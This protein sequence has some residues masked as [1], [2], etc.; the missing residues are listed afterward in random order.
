[1]ADP[2]A[3]PTL[4][5]QSTG[6]SVTPGVG[7]P[8]TGG[9]TPPPPVPA[10]TA[11]TG[12]MPW[13]TLGRTLFGRDS[14]S[15]LGGIPLLG[16]VVGAV[17][18]LA[19][20]GV[21]KPI[22]GAASIASHIPLGWLPG[23]ADEGFNQ[24][25]DWM[26]TN[27]PAAYQEW[28]VTKAA[29]D[30]DVLGGGN[31]R[32]DFNRQWTEHYAD[33]TKQGFTGLGAISRDYE[34]GAQGVGSLGGALA[35]GI[36]GLLGIL[37]GTVQR[38]IAGSQVGGGFGDM[39][40]G[41]AA[42]VPFVGPLLG[43]AGESARLAATKAGLDRVAALQ[44]VDPATLSDV[45]KTAVEHVKDG[46]WT[47]DHALNYLVTHNQSY[48]NEFL[49]QLAGQI[50]TDPLTF[51]TMGAGGISKAGLTAGK[52]LVESGIPATTALERL[53]V[54]AHTVQTSSLGPAFRVARGLIDPLGVMP[55]RTVTQ[56]VIDLSAG[57]AGAAFRRA[58]GEAAYTSIFP[59]AAK[60]GFADDLTSAIGAYEADQFR[61][62]TSIDARATQLKTT[63]GEGLVH[64][65]PDDVIEPMLQAAPKDAVDSLTTFITKTSK[66]T[67]NESDIA[68]LASRMT[69]SFGRTTAEWA[70]DIAKMSREEMSAWHAITYKV[71][72]KGYMEAL[73][74][75]DRSA[76]KGDL[77]LDQM[78]LMND[79][80]L[81]DVAAQALIADIKAEKSLIGK[82]DLW[83]G[84]ALRYSRIADL[85]RSTG[86]KVHLGQMTAALDVMIESLPKRALVDELN[87]PALQ[88]LND[89]LARNTIDG[90]PLWNLGFRPAE[91]VAWGMKRHPVSGNWI[92]ERDPTISHV[93][94][95]TPA[96]RPY[97][98]TT[99]NILGQIIGIDK[100]TTLA[101]PVDSV[102][103]LAR[104]ATDQVSGLRLSQNMSQRFERTMVEDLKVPKNMAREIFAKARELAGWDRTTI[105]GLAP[106]ENFWQQMGDII[107]EGMTVSHGGK[108]VIL[109]KHLL[110]DR[111][112]WAAEGDAR[113][114]GL[115]SNFTQR[116]RNTLRRQGMDSQNWAGQMTVTMYN[117]LR[118]SQPTFLIQRIADG[119]YFNALKGVMPVGRTLY[120]PAHQALS[121]IM[122]NI[123][124]TAM[125]RDFA[126]DM[127][128]YALR[129]QFSQSLR[130]AVLQKAG[131]S[132]KLDAIANTPDLIVRNNMIAQMH[133][134]LGEVLND[135]LNDT[136]TAIARIGETD[137]ATAAEM[138][139]N[140]NGDLAMSFAHMREVFSA[141][142]GRALSDDEVGLK[143]LQQQFASSAR[144]TVSPAGKIDL[145]GI[146]GEA[147]YM[148]PADI[149]ELKALPWDAV[150]HAWGLENEVALRT[151][152]SPIEKV[153]TG[154]R[155]LPNRGI[156]AFVEFLKEDLGAHPDVI[157]RFTNAAHFRWDTYWTG[158]REDLGLSGRVTSQMQAVIAQSAT[159]RGMTP[160]D[161]LSQMMMTNSGNVKTSLGELAD[162][163][164]AG[165]GKGDPLVNLSKLFRAHLDLSAQRTL[166]EEFL[167][168][169][170]HDADAA[171]VDLV[172]RRAGGE[173]IKNPEVEATV[174][175]FSK[176][177]Q[178][179]FVGQFTEN[180]NLIGKRAWEL[181]TAI[182]TNRAF[183]FNH[184][185]A[186]IEQLLLQKIGIA[187]ADAFRLA[188]M[189]TSRN[190]VSRSLN[191]PVFGMYPS[192]YMWG[193][194]LPEMAKFVA[195]NPYAATYQMLDVE[196]AIAT[197]REYD[198]KFANADGT[199]D[200]SSVAFLTGYL[201]P[202]LPWDD[203]QAASPPWMRAAQKSGFDPGMMAAAE[204]A[205]ISP[206]RWY[207][208]FAQSI[209]ETI[210]FTQ[211][212]LQPQPA[213]FPGLDTGGPTAPPPAPT[214]TAAPTF[215]GPTSGANIQPVLSY[216]MDQLHKVLTAP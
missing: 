81:D 197:Q 1:M 192:S 2:F 113:I 182:P 58:Y 109:D 198:P 43:N 106:S 145:Q 165:A 11:T 27:D 57:A 20:I 188:E 95:A 66:P 68:Q 199:L 51:A 149:G 72:D 42:N 64:T 214:S 139:A 124:R 160:A 158:L 203:M 61:L 121:D 126:M 82:R 143:Y 32:A 122:G 7:S 210:Q 75:V 216:D 155:I 56:G 25:G 163:L 3:P 67:W 150:A 60:H 193:K 14:G 200:K 162:F 135:A 85:G 184:T 94:D 90:Q 52:A 127:P 196:R 175:Q 100:A 37:G 59:M 31:T 213:A 157:K 180:R 36:Q 152:I 183:A 209:G 55:K 176:W 173:V 125:G 164:K 16:D 167:K 49:P 9:F 170:L 211:S 120:D 69:A 117:R 116:M 178:E 133:S 17:G 115:T 190:V 119:P 204:I 78:I 104:T 123:G 112:L 159:L 138:T 206:E 79:S 186:L 102:E 137:P 208:L 108:E 28:Q 187:E 41:V 76:Y 21:V 87:D 73:A 50:A 86:S 118:Y 151:A 39:I 169:G 91:D 181:V 18:N 212:Q 171:F 191:H 8:D 207:K 22:E 6:P 96:V 45:E 142:A 54:V 147:S 35:H 34:L 24:L 80:T 132:Q 129:S 114:V 161:Y 48:S 146:I 148:K 105:R 44:I 62:M 202:S 93:A 23:G 177:V 65:N 174:Q 92:I 130:D 136:R 179:A 4:P 110:L 19:N 84:A 70:T 88:P 144:Q 101:R 26:K 172:A 99:R 63:L 107:P 47:E 215:S 134:H 154:G 89:F 166:A 40:K 185:E 153:S 205:T 77:P 111:L 201:T 29:S 10:G 140:M 13:D 103:A 12:E 53:S 195:R 30:A 168:G 74:T 141:S 194:A 83:N 97:S 33:Q 15:P 131:L 71:A 98:D 38:G 46:S 156:D 128:E 5:G 189:A